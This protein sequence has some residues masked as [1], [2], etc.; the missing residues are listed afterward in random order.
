MTVGPEGRVSALVH[1]KQGSAPKTHQRKPKRR[2]FPTVRRAAGIWKFPCANAKL[3]CSQVSL[4]QP[5]I[6]ALAPA[7]R[8][9][10]SGAVRAAA[11]SRQLCGIIPNVIKAAAVIVP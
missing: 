11:R 7:S 4:G 6:P 1:F 9:S 3:T 2:S 8:T 10:D 5:C